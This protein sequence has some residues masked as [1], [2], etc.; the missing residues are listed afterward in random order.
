PGMPDTTPQRELVDWIRKAPDRS[1]VYGSICTG[2]FVLGHAGLINRR[3]VTT[4]W[5]N[6]A[7]L[8][9]TFPLAVVEPDAIHVQDGRLVTS[10]GVTAGIDLALA[11]VGQCHGVDVARNVAK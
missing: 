1:G 8:A 4:H 10:A 11:L 3:R 9:S 7:K 6:A 2:A 5:Q